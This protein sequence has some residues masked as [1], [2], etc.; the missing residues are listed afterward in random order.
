MCVK[1]WL[2]EMGEDLQLVKMEG[3]DD[4]ILGACERFGQD[5][6]IA[7]D[8]DKVI[9]V[10]M[11]NGMTHEEAIEWFNFNQIGAWVGDT[12]PCFITMRG[13]DG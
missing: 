6:I 11:S 5:T 7:Y 10:N 8:M 2:E 4:C 1:E 13:N 12:T 9:E 3:Y